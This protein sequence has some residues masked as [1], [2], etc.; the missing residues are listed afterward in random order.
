[1]GLKI[2]LLSTLLSQSC[3]NTSLHAYSEIK[4]FEVNYT[5]NKRLLDF[6]TRVVSRA[7]LFAVVKNDN[8]DLVHAYTINMIA[9]ATGVARHK[10]FNTSTTSTIS[11][12]QFKQIAMLP[13][14]EERTNATADLVLNYMAQMQFALIQKEL[15]SP[16]NYDNLY[17]N[18]VFQNWYYSHNKPLKA[19]DFD[20]NDQTN[21]VDATYQAATS[22]YIEIATYFID[23]VEFE[24]K[25]I[26]I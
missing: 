15:N 26:K 25:S 8:P 23:I 4:L 13:T 3:I 2:M 12:D 20:L 10:M 6:S 5:T 1:M 11:A 24:H 17:K 22:G 9:S 18:K 14:A 21:L 16:K 7:T 19:E